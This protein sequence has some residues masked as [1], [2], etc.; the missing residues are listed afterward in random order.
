MNCSRPAATPAMISMTVDDEDAEEV[1]RER[2]KVRRD[3]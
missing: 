3:K 2:R 1:E